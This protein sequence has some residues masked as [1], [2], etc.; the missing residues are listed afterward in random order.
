MKNENSHLLVADGK[1]SRLQAI[2]QKAGIRVAETSSYIE[3]NKTVWVHGL[4]QTTKEALQQANVIIDETINKILNAYPAGKRSTFFKL[5]YGVQVDSI[6]RML[7]TDIFDLLKLE[8]KSVRNFAL[9]KKL[10]I[11]G[12]QPDA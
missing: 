2:K 10:F 11:D 5:K 8:T 1:S 4:S 6:K 3:G 7:I 9:I 12:K